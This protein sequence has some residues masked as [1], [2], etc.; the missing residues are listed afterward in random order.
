MARVPLPLVTMPP[1]GSDSP[2][3]DML[4]GTASLDE[5]CFVVARRLAVVPFG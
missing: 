1:F 2:V 5:D 4:N 3:S